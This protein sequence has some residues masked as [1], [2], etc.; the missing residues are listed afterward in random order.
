MKPPA[1]AMMAIRAN[2]RRQAAAR[3]AAAEKRRKEQQRQLEQRKREE[4]RK[5]EHRN[6][7]KQDC[8][9]D[10][11]WSAWTECSAK[12]GGGIMEAALSFRSV[13]VPQDKYGYG[14]ACPLLCDM[15]S[16]D[17]RGCG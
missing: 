8:V 10:E 15:A 12:C 9:V 16:G 17:T 14:K 11:A 7:N 6:Q 3:R 1:A 5:L 4:K 2:Q 13:S